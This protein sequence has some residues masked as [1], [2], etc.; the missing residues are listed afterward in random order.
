MEETHCDQCGAPIEP[1]DR[2]CFT[3]GARIEFV[4]DEQEEGQVLEPSV[5]EEIDSTTENVGAKA[6]ETTA[7]PN[8]VQPAGADESEQKEEEGIVIGEDENTSRPKKSRTVVFVVIL[9]VVC[10]FAGGGV[11]LYKGFFDQ[12]V[13]EPGL[14]GL[15]QEASE[16]EVREGRMTVRFRSGEMLSPTTPGPVRE[17]HLSPDHQL[18]AYV[19]EVPGQTIP[20]GVGQVPFTE[21]R[22]IGVDGNQD[23][24]LLG[25]RA[26]ERM[27]DVLADFSYLRFSPDGRRL[28]FISAAWATSGALHR[29]DVEDGVSA[30]LCPGDAFDVITA[31][32]DAGK[33]RVEQHLPSGGG[34]PGDR[35]VL[36]DA[37]SGEVVSLALPGNVDSG[38]KTMPE[39]QVPLPVP[40]GKENKSQVPGQLNDPPR[41]VPGV[42]VR[43]EPAQYG[44]WILEASSALPPSGGLTYGPENIIEGGTEGEP[45]RKAWVEGAQGSG[46]GEW[47]QFRFG[48]ERDALTLSSLTIVNGY[49]K[50][51]EI[52]KKNNRVRQL[53][54]SH[55]AGEERV[56][57]SD[58]PYPQE[59][60]LRSPVRTYWIRLTIENIYR[61][62]T[63]D[64]TAVSQLFFDIDDLNYYPPLE[65]QSMPSPDGSLM[66][67]IIPKRHGNAP[68][69]ESM[70]QIWNPT[71]S[72][73]DGMPEALGSYDHSSESG[74]HGRV[75][76]RAGWTSDSRFFVYTTFSSGG[77]SPWHAEGFVFDRERRTMRSLS[78]LGVVI[79]RPNFTL[80]APDILVATVMQESGDLDGK[81]MRI[82]LSTLEK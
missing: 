15:L 1:G 75:V 10:G 42:T 14:P 34:G 23:R 51:D 48:K 37:D 9:L 2:F 47:I 26:S 43:L 64:D 53:R 38:K 76:D 24:L 41:D 36:V 81:S 70:V 56:E 57:L 32:A 31:G 18:I 16:V 58:S 62:S 63:Y 40:D 66:A 8:E 77:H 44:S 74:S 30:F 59:V 67:W 73:P 39:K 79:L 60:R 7:V 12:Q 4:R 33:L 28:F 22:L 13:S 3:C 29:V 19:R 61:G 52:F 80:E 6:A 50:S 45:P 65:G 5:Q 25:G 49:A 72:G 69:S 82:K 46:V 55:S 17:A 35:T 27:E 68:G 20:S 78:D 71:P 11:W 21:I 54:I